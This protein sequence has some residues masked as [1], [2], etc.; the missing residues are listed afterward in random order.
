MRRVISGEKIVLCTLIIILLGLISFT[1]FRYQLYAS[2]Y[3][4]AEEFYLGVKRSL[5]PSQANIS[6]ERDELVINFKVNQ[7]DQTNLEAFL[8]NFGMDSPDSRNL[9]IEL[10]D[11]TA[12]FID[13]VTRDNHLVGSGAAGI[14]LNMKILSKEIDF[15]NKKVFGPFDNSTEDLLENP[16]LE[17]SIKT[18]NIGENGYVIEIDNPEKVISEATLSGKLKVS[19]KL[20]DSRWWQLLFK[21][22]KIK[23]VIDNGSING[24]II[25]K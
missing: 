24:T 9:K 3:V 7:A 12:S 8:K 15:D 23:L 25:L 20:V 6:L 1:F 19:E 21:L 2:G 17:G 14:N 5:N 22:A 4:S 10:G 11:Q 16:S 13:K 18:Q